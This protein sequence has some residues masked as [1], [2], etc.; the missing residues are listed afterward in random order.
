MVSDLEIGN[1]IH[2]GEYPRYEIGSSA[3]AKPWQQKSLRHD[4]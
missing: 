3:L 4:T 2:K 1:I